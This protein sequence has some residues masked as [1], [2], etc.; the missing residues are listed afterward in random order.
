MQPEDT[1]FSSFDNEISFYDLVLAC[2]P[3]HSEMT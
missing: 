3:S 2:S 1:I